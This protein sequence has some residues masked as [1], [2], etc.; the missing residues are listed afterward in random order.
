MLNF[1]L[2][3]VSCSIYHLNHKGYH[4][5]SPPYSMPTYGVHSSTLLT[6][7]PTLCSIS[8]CTYM[9]GF[10]FLAEEE[11]KTKGPRWR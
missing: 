6:L 11:E 5:T 2:R 4:P 3:R 8:T 1:G 7:I 10:Y 9:Q